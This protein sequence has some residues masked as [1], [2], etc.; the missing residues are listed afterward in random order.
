MSRDLSLRSMII[1]VVVVGV[2]PVGRL[3]DLAMLT[4]VRRVE[5]TPRE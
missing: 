2:I 4:C 3:A 5:P 1:L